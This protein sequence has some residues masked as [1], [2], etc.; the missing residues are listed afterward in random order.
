V[1]AGA[2]FEVSGAAAVAGQALTFSQLGLVIQ[3]A[4][5]NGAAG[6]VSILVG[7]PFS[8]GAVT[9]RSG[10]IVEIDILADPTR[11][12]QLDLTILDN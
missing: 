4:L 8:V 2:S 11:L 3:P 1:P 9:V 5:I 6:A 12:R 7:Q 10:K